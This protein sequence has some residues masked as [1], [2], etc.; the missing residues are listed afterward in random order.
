[1]KDFFS[2]WIT[3]NEL[4]AY[5]EKISPNVYQWLACTQNLTNTLIKTGQD[6][7]LNLIQQSFGKPH[8]DE[9]AHLEQYTACAHHSFIR[10]VY[11]EGNN[12]PFIFARVIV[13]EETYFNYHSLF[14]T[15]GAT[16]IGN[17]L[18]YHDNQVKRQHFEFT[19]IGQDNPLLKTFPELSPVSH[20]KDIWARR[21]IFLYPKGPLLI[22]EFF[23]E[24]IPEHPG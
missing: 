10:K 13:P 2:G 1:M 20:N 9:I 17:A 23:S 22:S 6:F 21:S 16:P 4:D 18:L 7:S 5:K 15:L 14:S 8:Q 12:C 11:L 3:S 19:F 24:A